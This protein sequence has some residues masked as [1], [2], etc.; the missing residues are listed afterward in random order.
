MHN[1]HINRPVNKLYA[2]DI[3]INETVT[4][5]EL[6]PIPKHIPTD[7]TNF[8]T[9]DTSSRPTRIAT[10]NKYRHIDNHCI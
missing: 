1:Q 10:T 9:N 5:H 3:K 4:N 8:E 7:I 2:L 6:K